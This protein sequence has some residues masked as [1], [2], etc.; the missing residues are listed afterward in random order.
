MRSL[1]PGV[2]DNALF[3][4]IFI[5]LLPTNARDAAVKHELLEDMAE[6][7]DKVLAEAPA[8]SSVSA[9]DCV[10]DGSTN[11]ARVQQTPRKS[12]DPSLCYIHNHYGR[13][14]YKCAS[15]TTCR[16]KNI[17]NRSASGNANAGRR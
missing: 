2:P 5:D 13:E 14:A 3:E 7:A 6:A 11:L 4:A 1:L 12:K 16:M 15:P 8:V 10:V 17:T 9:I